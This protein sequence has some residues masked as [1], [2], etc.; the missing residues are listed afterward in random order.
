MSQEQEQ[1]TFPAIQIMVG[2]N[3]VAIETFFSPAVSIKQVIGEEQVNEM[4]KVWV[5]N[6]KG[7]QAQQQL[8]QDVMRSKLH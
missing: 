7:L 2:Q 1:V 6:R 5:A 3:G 4:L 8:V